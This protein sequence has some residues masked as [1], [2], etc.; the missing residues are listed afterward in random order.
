VVAGSSD[1]PVITADPLLGI[2]D[3]VLRRTAGG[4]V[5]GPE[6]C[7]TA[8]DAL[9]LYTQESAFAMHAEDE[10]GSLKAGKLADFVVLDA[11]PLDCA[12]ERIADIQVLATVIGGGPSTWPTA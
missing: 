3:A 8:R 2:R 11:N 4:Q 10:I 7:L 12:L 9:T 5:L 1:A 6:E